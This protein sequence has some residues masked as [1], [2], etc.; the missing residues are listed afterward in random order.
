MAIRYSIVRTIAATCF[1]APVIAVASPTCP[2]ADWSAERL[3]A[4]KAA[5]FLV[6]D[7]ADRQRLALGLLACLADPDPAL[8]DGVAFEAYATWLRA[9]KLDDKTQQAAFQQLL[10]ALAPEATDA[11]GFRQPFAALVLSEL[12]RADRQSPVL[13]AAQRQQLIEAAARYLETVRDYR[14]YD[15]QQG[16][17]HGVAHASDLLMQLALN[18]TLDKA[19]LDRMLAAVKQQVAPSGEH[20]YVYGESE[21]LALPLLFAARR[22]LHSAEEWQAWFTQ[23]AVPTPL[24]SWGQAFQSNAGLARRHNMRAFLLVVYV[25]AS[26]SKNEHLT[27]LVPAVTAALKSM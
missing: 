19:Q 22:G 11:A 13:T 12:A 10:P 20:F 14:G 4:L 7:D 3:L 23:L 9:G 8:R 15:S 5:E 25:E 21:R 16:W 2:P 17:R 18:E 1:L 6:P 24:A 26:H 27:K